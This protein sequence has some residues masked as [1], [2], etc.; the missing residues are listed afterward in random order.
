MST[1][2]SPPAFMVYARDLIASPAVM[3]MSP[4]ARGGFLM[5]MCWAWGPP[6]H[7]DTGVETP[8]GCLP[9]HPDLLAQLTMRTDPRI[10]RSE[11]QIRRTFTCVDGLLKYEP[12]L[13]YKAN[14]DERRAK[15]AEA[16]KK[17]NDKKWSERRAQKASQ[18]DRDPIAEPSQPDRDPI[19]TA[20]SVASSP[21]SSDAPASASPGDPSSPS[22]PPSLK[23][24]GDPEPPKK[25]K[26]PE[27]LPY[28]PD[29]VQDELR[30][31]SG[32]RY[33]PSPLV[34]GPT[35]ALQSQI[36]AGLT[37]ADVALAGAWLAAGGDGYKGTLDGRALVKNLAGWVAQAKAWH[38]RGRGPIGRSGPMPA[39]GGGKA[40]TTFTGP[41]GQ[42]VLK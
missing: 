21:A 37:L 29:D 25:E 28:T 10:A 4:E 11:K 30:K 18:G 3:L 22:A 35:I 7:P 23:L 32:S 26:K 13:S 33:V 38:A 5:L 17:G 12:H 36:K 27:R 42:V 6:A 34:K 15:Q 8:V 39:R 19:A 16:G 20:S 31:S 9:D 2:S 24:V 41:S 1:S 40:P 14:L